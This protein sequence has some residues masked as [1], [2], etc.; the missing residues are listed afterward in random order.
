[1]ATFFRSALECLRRAPIGAPGSRDAWRPCLAALPGCRVHQDGDDGL[2]VVFAEA[3]F[4][5]VAAILKPRRRRCWSEAERAK[6]S[7]SGSLFR[8]ISTL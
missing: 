4:E 7:A 5:A 1:M 8:S 6:R 3:M 2:T